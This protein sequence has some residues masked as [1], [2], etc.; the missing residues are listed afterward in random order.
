MIVGSG[1]S[2]ICEAG[3][4][5]WRPEGRLMLPSWVWRQ[6]G[7]RIHPSSE[8]LRLFCKGPLFCKGDG[9]LTLESAVGWMC[10]PQI[11]LFKPVSQD[12]DLWNGSLWGVIRSW[13]WSPHE[14]DECP[15]N[16]IP[17]RSFSPSSV[18]GHRGKTAEPGSGLSP[19]TD[20]ASILI[21][22]F[23]ASRTLR[24]KF[25]LF[26]KPLSLGYSVIAAQMDSEGNLLGFKFTNLNCI[27]YS[28]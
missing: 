28:T 14:W 24:D 5:N 12:G 1:K 15:Y 22:D 11:L 2:E 27:H 3:Q 19:D 21:L 20:Y 26:F 4:I 13:G 23:P 25:L 10:L 7:S 6:S 16:K 18:W 17:K 8:E 9:L